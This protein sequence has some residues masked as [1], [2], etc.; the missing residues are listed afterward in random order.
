MNNKVDKEAAKKVIGILG[1]LWNASAD[2]KVKIAA[3]YAANS[4]REAAGITSVSLSDRYPN[5]F[6]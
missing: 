1:A 6:N 3:H 4:L 5:H 2:E